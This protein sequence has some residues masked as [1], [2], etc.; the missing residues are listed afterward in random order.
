GHDCVDVWSR[1]DYDGADWS[2]LFSCPFTSFAVGRYGRCRNGAEYY[3]LRWQRSSYQSNWYCPDADQC[4]RLLCFN[5]LG[6]K[7]QCTVTTDVAS[8]RFNFNLS[9]I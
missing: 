9:F 8:H 6:E 7:G 5:V 1:T 4:M 3:L 2:F